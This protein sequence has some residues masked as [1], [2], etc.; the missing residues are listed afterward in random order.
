MLTLT[1]THLA[2]VMLWGWGPGWQG[3]DRDFTARKIGDELISGL[4]FSAGLHIELHW[5]VYRATAEGLRLYR[6][7]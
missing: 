6:C 7:P 1:K 4:Y 5:A 2:E 3:L